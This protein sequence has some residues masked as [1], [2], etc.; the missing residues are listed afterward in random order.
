MKIQMLYGEKTPHFTLMDLNKKKVS[1]KDF[2]GKVVFLSF[3]AT[4][5]GP[6]IDEMPSMESL[7]RRFREKDFIIFIYKDL[8]SIVYISPPKTES[9][10]KQT[11]SDLASYTNS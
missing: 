11:Y 3:W 7:Y 1:L 8:Y 5:C 4:W 2:E 6:C 10:K 9:F